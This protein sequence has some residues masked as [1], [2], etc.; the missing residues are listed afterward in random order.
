MAMNI[1]EFNRQVMSNLS[2]IKETGK[3]LPDQCEKLQKLFDNLIL[4]IPSSVIEEAEIEKIRELLQGVK[5]VLSCVLNE[6]DRLTQ[7]VADLD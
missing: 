5:E 1:A 7:K 2:K 6:N 3:A 4:A